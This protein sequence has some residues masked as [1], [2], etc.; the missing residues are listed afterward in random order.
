[1]SQDDSTLTP[2]ASTTSNVRGTSKVKRSPAFDDSPPEI[3]LEPVGDILHSVDVTPTTALES[4]PPTVVIARTEID[5]STY[6]LDTFLQELKQSPN[7][8]V[9]LIRVLGMITRDWEPLGSNGNPINEVPVPPGKNPRD[10]VKTTTSS[11]VHISGFRLTTIFGDEVATIFKDSPKWRV[12]IGGEYQ[13][14]TPFVQ[15]SQKAEFNAK[16]FAENKLR[17]K[18]FII[19]GKN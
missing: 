2:A 18:G 10:F 17:E 1:M 11:A 15:H 16:Q 19:G 3:T 5:P 9:E 4:S 6:V 14:D 13:I 7:R 12:T 8:A